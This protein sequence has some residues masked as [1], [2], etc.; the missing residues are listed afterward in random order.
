VFHV[1]QGY[2]PL[3]RQFRRALQ[4]RNAALRDGG[5][6]DVLDAWESELSRLAE[7]VDRERQRYLEGLGPL[8]G[9]IGQELLGAPVSLRYQRGWAADQDLAAALRSQRETDRAMGFT[10][11]GP[12]RADLQ[13]EIDDERSRWRASKGQQKLLA[14]AVILAQVEQVAA[15]LERPVA[16]VVDEPAADLD[17]GRLAALMTAIER[18]P[19]QVFMAAITAEGLP[20]AGSAR[21]FHVEHGDLKPCYTS[22][23]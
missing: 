9:R 18:A 4:Q 6:A 20:I 10:R 22:R 5:A 11:A 19:A 1:E 12:Q 21:L 15:V 2:L 14:S 23:N 8:F 17:A 13:F 7:A 3:W 16:L